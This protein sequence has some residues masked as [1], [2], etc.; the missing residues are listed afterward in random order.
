[1]PTAANPFPYFPEAGNNGYIYIGAANQDAQA[2]PVTAYRDAALTV[3][4]AQPIR[5]VDGYPAYQGATEGIF[6]A[7]P[8][9]SITVK[10]RNGNTFVNET[11][12]TDPVAVLATTTGSAL[13]G[14]ATGGTVEDGIWHKGRATPVS[15]SKMAIEWL[16]DDELSPMENIGGLWPGLTK[17]AHGVNKVFV[18]G[19]GTT[20]FPLIGFFSNVKNAGASGQVVAVEGVA[21]ATANGAKIFGANFISFSGNGATGTKLI[22]VEID[23]QPQSGFTP[24]EVL[25]LAVNCFTTQCP[26]PAI[27]INGVFGGKFD[28]GISVGVLGDLGAGIGPGAGNPR[29]GSLVDTGVANYQIAAI[30]LNNTHQIRLDGT[31]ATHARIYNDASNNVRNVLGSG[32]WIWRNSGDTTSL[33]SIDSSGNFD[34]QAGG[35]V[36]ISGTQ[37]VGAR[38]T[39]WTAMT[40]SPDKATAYAT[41]TVT[42]AQLAGRVAFLQAALTAH[43]L[44]GS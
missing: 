40:G 23:I 24:S 36:R 25:G 35:V 16:R 42:L 5:T 8:T 22:G 11:L 17:T 33:A 20:D 10:D 26:G 39:G 19:E 32:A 15:G 12:A 27:Y 3:P 28:T 14:A 37:V 6:L 18:T 4:W 29:M 44:I 30:R 34:L 38:D 9:Y 43:G 41:G 2:V 13:I 31:G 21:E 7:N 1:M